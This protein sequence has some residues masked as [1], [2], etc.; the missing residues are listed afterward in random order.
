MVFCIIY[1]PFDVFVN[2]PRVSQK[3]ICLQSIKKCGYFKKIYIL[4]FYDIFGVK[5]IGWL[6]ECDG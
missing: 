1:S 4:I 2:I 3:S 5:H 6:I